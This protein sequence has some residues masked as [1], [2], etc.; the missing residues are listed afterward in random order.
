GDNR[1]PFIGSS[2]GTANNEGFGCVGC[3]GRIEDAGNDGL[4]AGLGAGLRQHHHRSE[5]STCAFCHSDADP[6]NYT[7]FGEATPPPYYGTVD[8]NA[9][10][11]CNPTD[12]PS[13]NWTIGD[14]MGLDNDGNNL[15]DNND[16][17]CSTCIDNDGDGVCI[18]EDNCPDT[19]NAGQ[20]DS[21]GDGLGDACD[22][23]LNDPNNDADNDGVCG[24]VDN[25]PDVANPDQADADGDGIGDACDSLNDRDG[26]GVADAD[27]NCPDVANPDQADAD[28]DGIGDVCNPGTGG[29]PPYGHTDEEH[30]VFHMPGKDK[31][32]SNEC[33]S[34][35][36]SELNGPDSG[37]FAPSCFSCHGNEWEEEGGGECRG[38]DCD[39]EPD[40]DECRG[41]DCDDEPHGE[42]DVS[43]SRIYAP[44]KVELEM[45]TKTKRVVVVANADTKVQNA[46]ITLSL[47][48]PSDSVSVTIDPASIT[49]QIR[50]GDGGQKIT[51]MADI[52]CNESGETWNLTWEAIIDALENREETNN[53]ITGSTKVIC[54]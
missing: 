20:A 11:P 15:Y 8:T 33:T 50:L 40:D 6:A 4:S 34:C 9:D 47:N 24:D 12:N 54:E 26:D 38:D 48:P 7:P 22:T 49:K 31:P 39:D 52:T 14:N 46:T 32:F 10:M 25:C 28:G 51:F 30:G 45:E 41:D 37:G 42:A 13:E 23:C 29:G 17:D 19:Y 5:I 2:D 3:H 36:G 53:T 27:D 18:E 1:N 35:H 16:L 44:K 21:D 43:L